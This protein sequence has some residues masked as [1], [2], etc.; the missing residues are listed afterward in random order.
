MNKIGQHFQNYK[1]EIILNVKTFE[2]QK[3]RNE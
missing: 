3:L 1:T 2:L